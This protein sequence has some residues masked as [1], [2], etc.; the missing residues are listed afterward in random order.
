MISAKVKK[1]SEKFKAW[2]ERVSARIDVEAVAI[3]KAIFCFFFLFI[4]TPT[5]HL[6]A[7][8]QFRGYAPSMEEYHAQ[9]EEYHDEFMAFLSD[10]LPEDPEG[11][12]VYHATLRGLT[13]GIRGAADL[14]TSGAAWLIDQ[15]LS[16]SS[17]AA[18]YV[19]ES[20]K[21][22]KIHLFS[23]I[24]GSILYLVAFSILV[25]LITTRSR[26]WFW[27]KQNNLIGWKLQENGFLFGALVTVICW[28]T[29]L[30]QFMEV[31]FDAIHWLTYDLIYGT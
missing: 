20:W 19:L 12:D 25:D 15:T 24:Y 11:D 26:R 16:L 14:G 2:S 10:Y 4:C 21:A 9:Q 13:Q 28:F 7:W 6:I 30:G 1:V 3:R 27:K 23:W 8:V 18:S 17:T 5:G 31:V 22:F 29:P